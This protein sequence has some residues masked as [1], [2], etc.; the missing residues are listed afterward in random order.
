MVEPI[1][2]PQLAELERLRG[3]PVIAYASLIDDDSPAMLYECLRQQGPTEQLDLVLSTTG[4]LVTRARQLALLLREYTQHLSILVPYRAWSAG[5]LLCLSANELILGPLAELGP[6]D[7]QMNSVGPI[8]SGATGMLSSQDV[9][10]FRE[11]AEHW[12]GV[13][14]EE[15]RIQV[16]AL[17]AQRIF[18]TSLSAFYRF[19]KLLS[20][21]AEELLAYQLPDATASVKQS[22]AQHLVGGCYSHD[23]IISRHDARRLGLRVRDT[24]PQEEMLLWDLLQAIRAQLTEHPE[25]REHGVTGLIASKSFSARLVYHWNDAPSWQKASTQGEKIHLMRWEINR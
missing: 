11:M 23:T 1:I 24:T 22:I 17:I 7:A 9:Q 13:Q 16:L 25:E 5:T 15:D 6:I 21:T 19:D 14:R 2:L 12:F 8:P 3:N 18:P 10:A 20:Q 4:G